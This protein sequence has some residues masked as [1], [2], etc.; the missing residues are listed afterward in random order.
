M[1]KDGRGNTPERNVGKALAGETLNDR[2]R[3]APVRGRDN[4]RS[5]SS[6][7]VILLRYDVEL[8][9]GQEVDR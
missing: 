4:H 6:D 7:F 2:R 3:L 1:G 9:L 5:Q 8:A